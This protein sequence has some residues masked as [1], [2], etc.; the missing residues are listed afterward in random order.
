MEV[1]LLMCFMIVLCSTR[2]FHLQAQQQVCSSSS[3]CPNGYLCFPEP[4]LSGNRSLRNSSCYQSSNQSEPYLSDSEACK[5]FSSVI[6]NATIAPDCPNC[7]VPG[8]AYRTFT[9]SP[10]LQGTNNAVL[11]VTSFNLSN[12]GSLRPCTSSQW[13]MEPMAA[14]A[15][16]WYSQDR[17]L[18]STNIQVLAPN[19]RT[20]VARMVAQC[21][22]PDGCLSDH[23]FTEPCA[24]NAV[25]GNEQVWRQLGY[26]P[27]IGILRN[28][29]WSVTDSNLPQFIRS[30]KSYLGVIAGVASAVAGVV[31]SVV[32]FVATRKWRRS[33]RRRM[34]KQVLIEGMRLDEILPHQFS[35]HDLKMATRNFDPELILGA[36]GFGSVFKG[37]LVDGSLVAVKKMDVEIQGASKGH[38]Q[39]KAEVMSIGSIHHFN[40]V[41]LRGF[42]I[43]GPAALLVYEFMPNGSLD[44]WIFTKND[45]DKGG[46]SANL[47][48]NWNQRHLI[49]LDVARGL[50]YLHE[51]CREQ[52]LHLDI[53][54]QNIL[55]DEN[56]RARISDFGL[57]KLAERGKSQVVTVMRG[58]PGYM[59]PE[60]LHTKVT[61]K[62]DVYSFGIVLLELVSSKRTVQFHPPSS[63]SSSSSSQ[64]RF[65]GETALS[66]FHSG[67]VVEL[68][69]EKLLDDDF[70]STSSG[71]EL[72]DAERYVKIG[73]W[74]IQPE[75]AI[76]PSMRNV[77]DMLEG[78]IDVLDLPPP[79]SDGSSRSLSFR[80]PGSTRL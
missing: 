36:G 80:L 12:P 14:L 55:L 28:V 72:K 74:C 67:N 40:L 45:D 13:N 58:T 21:Y 33:R 65:L 29:T 19:G 2:S 61:D 4:M 38:S 6:L 53:K 30:K 62:T 50:T 3:D 60:W 43:Q 51:G 78:N 70:A 42:C 18:C 69:D 31:L 77:L 47:L 16:G 71:L 32:I 57:S 59:A 10:T 25:A 23:S 24:P 68:I 49:A 64:P 75:A 41:K 37:E 52:V 48:L 1:S 76:R 34:E 11:Y 73:L 35:Y 54:P 5:P 9:C 17:S 26:D 22:S 79:S 44:K 46:G 56:L 7:C 20:A 63:S 39:F 15:T 66:M 27:G 8:L